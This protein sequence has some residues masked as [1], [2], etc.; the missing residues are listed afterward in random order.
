M[1]I[2]RKNNAISTAEFA[3]SWLKG[4]PQDAGEIRNMYG[5]GG[6]NVTDTRA[7]WMNGSHND[8]VKP[9]FLKS[10]EE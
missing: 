2:T 5:Q 9:H 1:L 10:P 7:L 6:K 8:S 4:C 3:S